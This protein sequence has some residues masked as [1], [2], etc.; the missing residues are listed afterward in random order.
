MADKRGRITLSILI[1]LVILIGFF[2]L[3]F[4]L[5]QESNAK[6]YDSNTRTVTIK[7]TLLGKDIAKIKLVSELDV[8]VF[9]GKNR[10]V[11]EF[12]IQNLDT[13]SN[14]FQGIE[15][16]NVRLSNIKINRDFT[17]KYK[18][19]NEVIVPD[20]ETICNER[21]SANGSIEKYDCY[22]N[23]T[24]TH[25]RKDAVWNNFDAK[26]EL[27]IG[28]ITLGIFTDVFPNDKVEWIPTLFG[29][30]IDEWATWTDALS[31]GL[32]SYYKLNEASGAVIDS[33]N[34]YNGTNA[35]ATPNV[36]GK[37]GTA[38][39]FDGINDYINVSGAG[40]FAGQPFTINM[41][42]NPDSLAYS[43][44]VFGGGLETGLGC[45]A[46]YFDNGG[47]LVYGKR[48]ASEH[49]ST[50]QFST[51]SWQMLT[52]TYNSSGVSFFRNGSYVETKTVTDTFACPYS[53][54]IG[55]GSS[56]YFNGTID[57]AGIWN[58]SLSILE[59]SD[60]YN[61]G[62]GIT[63][64][65]DATPPSTTQ[66]IIIPA[67]PVT[68]NNLTCNATLTDNK[69]TT[70][71]VNWTWYNNSIKHLSGITEGIQ[72]G[73]N[74]IITTLASGNTTK[75]ENWIC[76]VIPYDGSNYG[77]ATNSTAV[78]ILNAAPSTPVQLSPANGTGFAMNS[79][80]TFIW[81]NSNDA[82]TD[83][84]TITYDLEIYNETNLTSANRVHL[85][86][87]ISQGTQN[88]S[89]NIKLSSYTTKDDDYYW[90]VRAYDQENYSNWSTTRT[91]QYANW[92]IT[93]N[94]TDSFTGI[95]IDTSGPLN[96]DISCNNGFN[97]ANV[98]NPYTATDRFAAGTWQCTFSE[99]AGY[100]DKT[101]NITAN[102]DK[103]VQISMSAKNQLTNEEHAWLEW[104]YTCWNSGRCK[105]LLE[106][107]NTTT[108]QTWQRLTG[109]DTSV[110]TQENVLSY[111]LNSTSNITIN[112]TINVPYKSGVAVNELLPIRIYF[113]FTD[114]ARTTCYSQ[115]KAN[116]TNRAESPYCLPLVAEILGP[117]NGSV[118]FRVDL[119]PAL[120]SG[121]YNFTRSIEIDPLGIWTQ[122]GREDI[123]QIEVLEDNNNV[124]I[125]FIETAK[126]FVK[127]SG[128]SSITGAVVALTN[129]LLLSG[130][131]FVIIISVIAGAFVVVVICRTLV[132]LKKK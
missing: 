31:V 73:T 13:S 94:L 81:N 103:T 46:I 106:N 28:N 45:Y 80:I 123:G 23:Q 25:I 132:S 26:A 78:T 30:R 44:A 89:I 117:N 52:I 14:V 10:K 74:T 19:Y 104:L 64:T 42:V 131:Q 121:T 24:G 65:P 75:G 130:W 47:N 90:R 68:T 51:G 39:D 15:F 79:T 83:N 96:F 6:T 127:S 32:V 93:F 34:N 66:P 43:D 33:L 55:A 119:R 7:N 59:V 97:V 35:G 8:K 49:I 62:T 99:L 86:T 20:Y 108:T 98:E 71:T 100:F 129:S 48:G 114:T 9:A 91:F 18:T 12:E 63:Y 72:N 77:N 27:P 3:Y 118:T 76:E 40:N 122:Y 41:W 87:S 107:I 95:Q 105:D 92:T 60:L 16:Y 120:S 128:I 22:E 61:N 84:P 101:Q 2:S 56:D 17:Y 82:D 38:Y 109:T 115:D 69:Q 124:N 116:N 1:I 70:L 57:E 126:S 36:S 4:V 125:G 54:V 67:N 29:F 11:A 21:A 53:Y 102:I 111:V 50:A 112:Y 58:R 88:T 5:A 85:N 110:I 113:W 37:I